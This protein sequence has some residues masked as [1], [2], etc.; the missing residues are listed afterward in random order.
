MRH[1]VFLELWMSSFPLLLLPLTFFPCEA[2]TTPSSLS[3]SI[4]SSSTPLSPQQSLFYLNF[5]IFHLHQLLVHLLLHQLLL[6]FTTFSNKFC[7]LLLFCKLFH[8][9][10][11]LSYLPKLSQCSL[12]LTKLTS[13]ASFPL[14][15]QAPQALP[16]LTQALLAPPMPSQYHFFS[17]SSP[18]ARS[19]SSRAPSARSSFSLFCKAPFH[20]TSFLQLS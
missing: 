17:P 14:L 3:C 20:S 11:L 18:N 16:I 6:Q 13:L 12:K 10:P 7:K 5:S 19:S 2:P 8:T 4:D 1:H 15:S 9:L